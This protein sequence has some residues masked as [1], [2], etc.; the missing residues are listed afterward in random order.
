MFVFFFNNVSLF[1]SSLFY[2]SLFFVHFKKCYIASSC[3]DVYI[4]FIFVLYISLLKVNKHYYN[5][6]GLF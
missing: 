2:L 1:F 3:E 4:L 5:V 6:K